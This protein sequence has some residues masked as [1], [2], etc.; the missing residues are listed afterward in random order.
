MTEPS[1]TDVVLKTPPT[2]SLKIV[3]KCQDVSRKITLPEDVNNLLDQY[4][5]AARESDPNLTDADV[6]RAIF[7]NHFNRDRAF[8]K[9]RKNKMKNN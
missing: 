7:L 8:M 2:I 3:K 1:N 5:A 6:I 4:V 9:W